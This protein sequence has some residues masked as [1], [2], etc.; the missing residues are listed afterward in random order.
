MYRS[1][2]ATPSPQRSSVGPVGPPSPLP[3]WGPPQSSNLLAPPRPATGPSDT[4]RSVPGPAARWVRPTRFV[5]WP[6][7]SPRFSSQ[8]KSLGVFEVCFSLTPCPGGHL[9]ELCSCPLSNAYPTSRPRWSGALK[10]LGLPEMQ[11][12]RPAAHLCV[13][14]KSHSST[15]AR[16]VSFTS[17]PRAQHGGREHELSARP[18]TACL[19]LAVQTLPVTGCFRRA[20]GVGKKSR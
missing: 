13:S 1:A 18:V 9:P 16:T 6:Y 15:L 7:L 10:H 19:S 8:G 14:P 12:H 4:L 2:R 17:V 3:A 5:T 20:P 11:V